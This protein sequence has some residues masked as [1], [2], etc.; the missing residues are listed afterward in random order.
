MVSKRWTVLQFR[1]GM[2]KVNT[3][4]HTTA[5][6]HLRVLGWDPTAVTG[7]VGRA[8][9]DVRVV[10]AHPRTWVML[11]RAAATEE[12]SIPYSSP[13]VP[14]VLSWGWGGGQYTN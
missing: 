10:E 13:M 7:G 3:N 4:H 2:D 8:S 9:R 1:S 5:S 14:C 12:P 6:N 11:P